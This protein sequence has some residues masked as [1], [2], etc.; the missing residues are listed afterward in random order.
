MSH[1][2]RIAWTDATWNPVTGCSKVSRGCKHCYAEHSRLRP[3]APGC[4]GEDGF[5]KHVIQGEIKSSFGKLI[6]Y[7]W[8]IPETEACEE[9][10]GDGEV[11]YQ[12]VTKD[13]TIP[14]PKCEGEDLETYSGPHLITNLMGEIQIDADDLVC[15][16]L[17]DAC[18]PE[19][20]A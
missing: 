20:E 7:R 6:G 2:S 13:Y 1:R 4:A 9:C 16:A 3:H 11:S 15:N 10:D 17:S 14:C 5:P 8:S 19:Q 18:D 12:G